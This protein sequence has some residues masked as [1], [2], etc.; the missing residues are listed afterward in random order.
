VNPSTIPNTHL[1]TRQF[2]VWRESIA[3]VFDVEPPAD[4]VATTFVASVEAFQLGDMIVTH[5]HLGEQRYVRSS[6]RV[7]RDGMD[8]FVLN[9]YRTAAGEPRRPKASSRGRRARSPCWISLAN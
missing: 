2:D 4:V 1:S 9:L 8:H 7:R 6:A 3:V 5:A